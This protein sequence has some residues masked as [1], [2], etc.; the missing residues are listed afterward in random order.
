[1]CYKY[2]LIL[3]SLMIFHSIYIF[4]S[5]ISLVYITSE[6]FYINIYNMFLHKDSYDVHF[7]SNDIMDRFFLMIILV[8]NE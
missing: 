8:R 4:F 7:I 1:M 6:I 2:L 3:L 5:L